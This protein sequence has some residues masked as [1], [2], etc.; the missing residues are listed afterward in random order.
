VKVNTQPV[1]HQGEPLTLRA[2]LHIILGVAEHLGP[3]VP[4]DDDFVGEGV[5]S[6]MV[7][8]IAIVDF[9]HHFSSFVW[10]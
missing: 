7:P 3:V 10:S 8:T 9:L 2:F 1:R 5:T 6:R 4:L